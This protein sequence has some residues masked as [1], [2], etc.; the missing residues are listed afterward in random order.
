[1]ANSENKRIM[2]N[3]LKN[4]LI[5]IFAIIFTVVIAGY[6]RRTGPTY[7]MKVKKE[8]GQ[9]F[10]R[11]ELIRAYDGQDNAKVILNIP[12]TSI[13][14]KIQ[15]RRFK[16]YDNWTTAAMIRKGD[17][18]IARLPHQDISGK[19]MYH[20]TLVKGNEQVL[21]NE[22]PAVLR[23]KGHVPMYIL[24]P[25][26]LIIFLA[27][28]FSTLAGLEAMT[29]GKH[30]YLYSWITIITLFIGG[31]VLGPIV[32]KFSFGVYWAGWPF[33]HDLTDNKSV[34]AFVF[35]VI[36]L[37]FQYRNREKK[38]WA[39]VASI[40]LLIVFLIPHSILGS[41]IDYTKLPKTEKVGR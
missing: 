35:W 31:L 6:Q 34:V 33:G 3:T 16:S 41:E 40:V 23:Y 2:N 9:K 17:S 28:L 39:I 18:L 32:Q 19:V 21:L 13:N 37:I 11:V 26:I 15:F 8:I 20:I 38:L 29:K 24:F 5:W 30:T 10:I 22:D 7:P 1:M 4:W 25:H 12:D 27:M 14:G 36:A